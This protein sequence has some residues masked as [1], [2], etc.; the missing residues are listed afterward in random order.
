MPR[1]PDL[2]ASQLSEVIEMALS[3]HVGFSLIEQQHGVSPD[4]VKA[5]MRSHLKPGSYKSWRKRV[6]EFGDRREHY[7]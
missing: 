2:S 7:K 4:Q 1:T 3:D 6:R 5:I